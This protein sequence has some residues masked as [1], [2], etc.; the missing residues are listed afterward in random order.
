MKIS[1]HFLES[2]QKQSLHLKN[3]EH[4]TNVTSSKPI[5]PQSEWINLMHRDQSPKTLNFQQQK[6]QLKPCETYKQSYNAKP[7][8]ALDNQPKTTTGQTKE[9]MFEFKTKKPT[10]SS[11]NWKPWHKD[12][13]A[14]TSNHSEDDAIKDDGKSIPDSLTQDFVEPPSEEEM[15]PLIKELGCISG[16]SI[17]LDS[18]GRQDLKSCGGMFYKENVDFVALLWEDLIFQSDNKDISLAPIKYSK[19]YKIYLAYATRAATPKRARKFKKPD[20]PSKK[21]THVLEDEPAKK[22][23]RAK[24]P[25]PAKE[26]VS[27]KKSSRKKSASVVI[28]YPPSVSM[29]KKKA[30]AKVNRGKGMDLLS[31]VALLEAAHLKKVLKRRKHDTHMLHASGLDDG[32]GS[33]PKVPDELQHKTIESRDDD[34]SND[35]HNDDDS[36]DDGNNVESDD[37]HEQ[38]DD[39]RTESDDEEEETQHDEFIHTPDDYAPT[40]D[41]INDES[42]DVDEE[43]YERINEEPYGDV[44]VSLTDVEPDDEDKGDKEM[45]NADTEDVEHE[46][47]IQESASNQFKDDAQATQKTE[48]VS[49]LDI[50]V[51]HEVPRTSPLLT[52]PVYIILEHTFVNPPETVTTASSTTISS[53]M[54]SLFPH[55]QQLTPIPTPTTTEA[56]NLTIVVPDS[57]TLSDFHQRITNMEK[58]VKELKTVDHSATLL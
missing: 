37:D 40:D 30:P 4:Y 56:K 50:N 54:S 15:V 34:D 3:Q 12:W 27:S 52:I 44:N 13:D 25:E 35:D 41:E 32:V 31:N 23:K 16:K 21:Q 1:N 26:D 18:L 49:M 33:Q 6:K 11:S 17:G 19:E 10:E 47:V 22:P 55:L 28:R 46:N 8:Y 14:I 36:D 24:H 58:D 51:Q 5:K 2:S 42:K 29:S 38:A 45:T 9:K 53:L 48:V 20:S 39:E 57:E 7:K 43:E